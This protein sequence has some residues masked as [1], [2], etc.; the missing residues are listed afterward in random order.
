MGVTGQVTYGNGGGLILVVYLM[1]IIYFIIKYDR[2]HI[3][4][5]T[6]QMHSMYIITFSTGGGSA[7][8]LNVAFDGVNKSSV[9]QRMVKAWF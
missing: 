5:M 1:Q 2:D 6:S 4:L 9:L 3:R 7:H 8:T